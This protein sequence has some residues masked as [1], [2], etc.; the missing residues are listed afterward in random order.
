VGRIGGSLPV[1]SGEGEALNHAMNHIGFMIRPE[2]N[3]VQDK[4]QGKEKA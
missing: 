1:G 2:L 4:V 3:V